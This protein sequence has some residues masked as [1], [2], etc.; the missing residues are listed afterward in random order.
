[1]IFADRRVPAALIILNRNAVTCEQCTIDSNDQ[2]SCNDQAGLIQA[3]GTK[4]SNQ[5]DETSGRPLMTK[6]RANH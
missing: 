4:G 1:V 5:G 3:A 6:I 2:L